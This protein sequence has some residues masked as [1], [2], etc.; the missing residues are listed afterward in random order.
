MLRKR[1]DEHLKRIR[2]EFNQRYYQKLFYDELNMIRRDAKMG[3]LY[4]E[5]VVNHCT[6]LIEKYFKNRLDWLYNPND[7]VFKAW[8]TP[9]SRN[10][11][12][13]KQVRMMVIEIIRDPKLGL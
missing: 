12:L 9:R 11:P 6:S 5:K 10:E 2:E 4:L 1:L 13:P 7:E 3:D 8:A